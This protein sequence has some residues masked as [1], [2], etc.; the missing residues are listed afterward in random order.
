MSVIPCPSALHSEIWESASSTGISVSISAITSCNTARASPRSAIAPNR[1]GACSRSRSSANRWN[2]PTRI[3][4]SSSPPEDNDTMRSHISV[5]AR[6]VNVTAII[7]AGD[8]PRFWIRSITRWVRTRVFPV[9]GPA[10]TMTGPL[11]IVM[12]AC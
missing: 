4:T 8:T 9:P 10:V 12:A 3:G 11:S 1:S 5:A 2:V 6:L 7:E